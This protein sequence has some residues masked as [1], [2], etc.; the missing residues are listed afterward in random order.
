VTRCADPALG[1]GSRRR[2]APGETDH[3]PWCG[4]PGSSRQAEH[5]RQAS[6]RPRSRCCPRHRRRVESVDVSGRV[7]P[8]GAVAS[9]ARSAASGQGLP[10][11]RTSRRSRWIAWAGEQ[12]VHV[13][14]FEDGCDLECRTWSERGV[15]AR[16]EEVGDAL[17]RS[18][19]HGRGKS[20]LASII[21]PRGVGPALEQC[22]H[23]RVDRRLRRGQPTRER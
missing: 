17:D 14:K 19:K 6:A 4:S 2:V 3:V 9:R 21:D 1:T 15:R 16:G 20:G 22:A 12:V 7:G 5:N 10:T 23:G 8:L 13:R 11:R 18:T